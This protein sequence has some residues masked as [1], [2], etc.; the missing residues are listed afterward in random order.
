MYVGMFDFD[1]MSGNKYVYPSLELMKLSAWHK[2]R[3]DIVEF[4]TTLEN[5]E[6]YDKFY[7]YK[8]VTS[9]K[10]PPY[11]YMMMD[12][13]EWY[14]KK[15]TGEYVPLAPEIEETEPDR[16]F[17]TTYLL[18]R[19]GSKKKFP[20]Q[21]AKIMNKDNFIYRFTSKDTLL[22]D[23]KK[24]T[25]ENSLVILFDY[26][27]FES[28]YAYEIIDYLYSRG[29]RIQLLN[30]S[31]ISNLELL[32][33][34]HNKIKNITG[35]K[36]GGL[37]VDQDNSISFYIK[38]EPYFNRTFGLYIPS[39][40]VELTDRLFIKTMNFFFYCISKGKIIRVQQARE[41]S[42][43][44]KNEYYYLF[45]ALNNFTKHCGLVQDLSL[46]ELSKIN[47]SPKRYNL[48]LNIARSNQKIYNL[49]NLKI[50]TIYC[51]EYWRL[52]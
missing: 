9:N 5:V 42:I 45:Q 24:E 25:P 1:M 31:L 52:L 50:Q 2:S 6:N 37:W 11:E 4:C 36:P 8:G 16:N 30:T 49:C 29:N 27:F 15:F 33:F 19:Y 7:I 20:T 17:Y 23:Y 38:N 26:D 41:D 18:S 47:Y 22:Y 43:A 28:K 35:S 13:V 46:L 10:I 40:K 48:I 32:K 14:G 39:D 51:N 34:C 3:G 21:I 12:N 44:E